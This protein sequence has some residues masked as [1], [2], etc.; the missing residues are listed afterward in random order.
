M[1][2]SAAHDYHITMFREILEGLRAGF[3]LVNPEN[4]TI[5]ETNSVAAELIGISEHEIVGRSSDTFFEKRLF[6]T[7]E[8]EACA[9]RGTALLDREDTLVRPDGHV[10][11]IRF[12]AFPLGTDNTTMVAQVFFDISEQKALERQINL[13]QKLESI[14]LLASGIAHE[15]NTPSQYI[16]DNLRFLQGAF[17]D[18]APLL[19]RCA[20]HPAFRSLTTRVDMPFL[21]E[22]IPNAVQQALNGIEHITSIVLAMKKF[23]HPDTKDKTLQ[24]INMALE[25]VIIVARN[26]LK[27]VADVETDFAPDL[28][29]IMCHPGDLNQV[30]LNLLV[31]AA[32]AIGEMLKGNTEADK[33]RILVRTRLADPEGT[34]VRIEIHDSGPGIPPE[35]HDKIFTPFFTTKDIGK[36]TGQGLAISHDIVV[37]KHD[38]SI[39][40]TSVPG[41]GTTFSITLPVTPQQKEDIR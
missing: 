3:I 5:I 40:F 16:G 6:S 33:G 20:E 35:L 9:L 32:Q 26:E 27:Y 19:Q 36:G 13:A 8:C 38:G 39:E 34:Q 15:I 37:R 12:S 29:E 30:F 1:S 31:N 7:Q 10:L 28:P 22:E 4:L 11:P 24:D 25:N 18:L 2:E 23:S 41:Q 17:E 14:G 21:L